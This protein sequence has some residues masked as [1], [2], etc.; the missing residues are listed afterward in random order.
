MTDSETEPQRNETDSIIEAA[1]LST[2]ATEATIGTVYL[3]PQANGDVK[4]IDL[5]TDDYRKRMGR[6]PVRKSGTVKVSE[7][8]SFSHYVNDH[9]DADAT[10]LWADR[11]AGRIIAVLNGH[12]K[13]QDEAG[14]GDHRSVLDLRKSPAW[15]AWTAASG[16]MIPQAEFAEFL[17]DRAGDVV[18]PD[19]ATLLEVATSIEGT[20]RAAYKSGVRLDNGEIQFRYEE[21]V[22]AKAGQRG[23]LTIPSQIELGISP[24]DGMDPYKVS[25]RFRY[26]IGDDLVL[27]LGVVLDRPEDVLRSAFSQVL[28]EVELAT[29]LPVLHGTPA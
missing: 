6:E 16:K 13:D 9:K 8:P 18:T 21:T 19:H 14:W 10:S 4:V 20:K 25:A 17:E 3:V 15:L 7:A 1:R 12:V 22:A 29:D 2:E 26:R 5:A 27:L 11:D 23:D 28:Q 24:F